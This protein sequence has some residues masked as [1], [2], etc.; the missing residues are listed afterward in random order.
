MAIVYR[1]LDTIKLLLSLNVDAATVIVLFTNARSKNNQQVVECFRE[2]VRQRMGLP[3]STG[4][5]DPLNAEI[6][7]ILDGSKLNYV[8]GKK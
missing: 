8:Y 4:P 3:P 1:S 7:G 5:N 6:D 2:S